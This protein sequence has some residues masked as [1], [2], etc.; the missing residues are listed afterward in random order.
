MK[1]RADAKVA[2]GDPRKS[3]RPQNQVKCKQ[4]NACLKVAAG[5]AT[6]TPEEMK[7]VES[8]PEQCMEK[9]SDLTGPIPPELP[10]L[11]EVNHRLNFID[12]EVGP[13][14]KYPLPHCADA[15]LDQL[16]DKIDQYE[17]A[18]WW[19][20]V[21]AQVA[22]PMLCI[23]KPGTDKLRTV[24]DVRKRNA[25]TKKDVTPFPDQDRIR[26]DVACAKYRTKIDMTDAYEQIRVDP[27]D[28]HCTTFAT[29]FGTYISLVMQQGDC[30]AP[31]MFQRL[32]THIF[33]LWIG[34]FIHVYLDDIFIYSDSIEDHEEHLTL[35]FRTL[36][37]NKLFISRKKLD[38]YSDRMI[39]LGH[40]I[41]KDGI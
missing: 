31:S 36:Q 30:N 25:H 6:R 17:N 27:K 23:Y 38:L 34:K 13:T 2:H 15:L 21:P 39:C 41:D 9:V 40:L 22:P 18:G 12:D 35:V 20:P 3:R 32:M 19:K 33:R 14:M 7:H 1:T 11:R 29:I 10:P 4:V 24:I 26:Y 28:V 16:R 8:L 5:A 37:K